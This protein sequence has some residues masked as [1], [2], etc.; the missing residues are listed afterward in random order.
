[1]YAGDGPVSNVDPSGRDF[2]MIEVSGISISV[3]VGLIPLPP[4]ATWTFPPSNPSRDADGRRVDGAFRIDPLLDNEFKFV[5][6]SPPVVATYTAL[7]A[8]R[9]PI[10]VELHS[11]IAHDG[12]TGET[13]FPTL[14]CATP[15]GEVSRMCY[16]L[17]IILN[18]ET[19]TDIHRR[20]SRLAHELSHANDY[21]FHHGDFDNEDVTEN[22]AMGF[23]GDYQNASEANSP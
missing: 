5:V 12:E 22:R 6:A 16:P 15:N 8:Q 9:L 20:R 23:E 1:M 17:S 14:D 21:F 3:L 18:P 4:V 19:L 10:L 2:G 11:Y 13:L 7:R